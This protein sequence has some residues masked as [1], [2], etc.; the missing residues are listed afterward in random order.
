MTFDWNIKNVQLSS[1]TKNN[2]Y[3]NATKAKLWMSRH[4]GYFCKNFGLLLSL[5]FCFFGPFLI[6]F[7]SYFYTNKA[8]SR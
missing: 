8:I 6:T 1:I 3:F 7:Y 5:N 4:S 2:Q